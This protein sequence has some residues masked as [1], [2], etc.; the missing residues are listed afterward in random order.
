MSVRV[1][2]ILINSLI[3]L[4]VYNCFLE[5]RVCSNTYDIL[6]NRVV[7]RLQGSASGSHLAGMVLS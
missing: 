2:Q 6:Q 3:E 1:P 7:N 5:H 4:R